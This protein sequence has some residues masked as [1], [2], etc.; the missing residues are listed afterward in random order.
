MFI[1]ARFGWLAAIALSAGTLTAC[2]RGE[3][4]QQ[5]RP[6]GG[7][8]GAVPVT[9]STIA[10][11]E[12]P[13]EIVGIGAAEAFSSV[14]IRAQITGE[15]TSVNFRQGDDVRAGQVL[16]T[17]DERPL[18]AALSQAEANL[19]RDLAQA[20]NAR[21]VANRYQDLMAKGLATRDQTGSTNTNAAALEATV[22]ADRAAVE[23]AKVQLQYATI[24][25][26]ISGRTGSLMV[27]AG[28]LV[29]ANDQTPLVVINQVSPMFVSFGIPEASL[30]QLRQFLAKGT[31]HVEA[32]PAGD[33]GP[34][35]VGTIT[36]VD[37]TV[38]QTTGTIK[39]KGTFPNTDHHLWPGQFVNVVVKLT[40]EQAAIVAPASAVQ[41]GP[42]GTFVFLVK[43][44]KTVAVQP[45]EV[46]R[47]AGE[48][49]VLKSG[50]KAG[51]VVVTDGQLR[52]VPGSRISI[53]NPGAAKVT[54]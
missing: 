53:K 9:V 41:N 27:N 22:A 37:N 48:E 13:V 18:Q 49:T 11:K 2:A 50:V 36:F 19:A 14:S 7:G 43:P 28:N 39:V 44:D 47:T 52:L 10:E 40:T 25:A 21:I 54:S 1:R 46:A 32:R 6:S 23:N 12:M 8:G 17:L 31:M 33:D 16:F 29:R 42:D 26:P 34:P 24:K 20:T 15:L 5:P 51:D 38:D 45:V 30:P 35:A 4:Q 3:A